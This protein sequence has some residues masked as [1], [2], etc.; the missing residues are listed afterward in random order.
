[1]FTIKNA[2]IN[3]YRY[4]SKYMIFGI[5]YFI[6]IFTS[7]VCI[8]VYV[9][10]AQVSDNINKEYASIL[11]FS[12]IPGSSANNTKTSSPYI[13]SSSTRAIKDDILKY[14]NIEHIDDIKLYRYNFTTL[15]LKSN[16]SPLRRELYINGNIVFWDDFHNDSFYILGYNTSLMYLMGKDDFK[17]EK[18]RMFEKDGEAVIEKNR[19]NPNYSEWNDLEIG[20][21]IVIQNDNGIYKEFTVVGITE[22]DPNID[23]ESF[24]C[25]IYTTIESA[26]YFDVIA[27]ERSGMWSWG[28]TMGDNW[29]TRLVELGIEKFRKYQIS[30]G[31]DALIFLDSYENMDNVKVKAQERGATIDPFFEDYRSLTK[32]SDNIGGE[33]IIYIIF[34]GVLIIGITIIAT[35]IFLNS[36]KYEI[37]VLRSVG[38]KKSRLIITYLIEN[39]V[40]IWGISVISLITSQFIAKIIAIRIFTDTQDLISA[41][42]YDTLKNGIN[43]DLLIKNIGFVFGG[44]SVV[45]ILSL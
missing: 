20:D 19:I 21:K 29:N 1:M 13:S 2:V 9:Q 43:F 11:K 17:L 10:M 12:Y 44:T 35:I 45:V 42:V 16:V 18:G 15:Y 41:Q 40:F 34:T 25:L 38:M 14:K 5:L 4:K 31:Y 7:S 23:M 36:R 32:L 26:E 6:L 28:I 22:Q 8:N 24:A 3:V 30:M 37:A 33:V 39:L 27:G